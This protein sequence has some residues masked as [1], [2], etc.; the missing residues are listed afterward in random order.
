M[1]HFEALDSHLQIS[2]ALE[3]GLRTWGKPPPVSLDEWA[4][5]NFHLSSES[6]YIE[7]AWN[8]WPFQRGIMHA[9]SRD[10]I[11]EVTIKKSARVGYTKM[12]LAFLLY[13]AHHRRRNQ[14]IWLPSDGDQ[15]K[16]VKTELEPALRDVAAMKEV[17][18]SR[19]MGRHRDNTLTQKKFA[20]CL[21]HILGGGSAKNYRSISVDVGVFDELSA[22]EQDI[23]GEGS[24]FSLGAKRVAGATFPKLVTGSTPKARGWCH[25]DARYQAADERMSYQIACPHCAG[26]HALSWGGPDEPHGF[27]FDRDTRAPDSVRHLCPHCAGLIDQADYLAAADAGV[28]INQAGDLWLH[29]DGR[30]TRHDGSPTSPPRHL[31]FHVWAAYS[32]AVSWPQLVREFFAAH[33]KIET[34]DASMM[35]AFVNTT[36]GDTW[37][38]EIER[39][40]ADELRLRAEPFALRHMPRGCLLLLC[41][42]DVQ[43]NRLE[44]QVWGIGRGGE[45]WSID[46]RVFFGNPGQ[47]DVWH[48]LEQFLLEEKY[49]HACGTEHGIHATAIDS[50]GHHADMVYAFAHTH[51]SRRVHAV[52]GSS[53]TER[54]I[55][56][57]N[58]KVGFSFRGKR[59]R[60][61][62]TLWLVGT[63]LA[64]DRLA[65][66]LEVTT[67]GPG[68][69]HLSNENSDEWFRQLAAEDRVTVRSRHGNQ[70][71]WVPNRKR[72]EVFDMTAYCI[73]LEERLNLWA[74]KNRKW[75][76][77]LEAKAEPPDLFSANPPPQAAKPAPDNPAD[78]HAAEAAAADDET[79][80]S[81]I[82]I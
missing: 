41:G 2:H 47:P 45:M 68:Y 26:H 6:S 34:G 39:T 60:N 44:A 73:W 1:I 53:G 16:F 5:Q 9:L 23:E 72:N 59:E 54:G 36:L 75:W 77:D 10:D 71:R 57:G 74:P 66:R 14:A 43:G 11:A 33:E 55:E 64:K 15:K 8:P 52:K 63:N 67:P 42:V 69:I 40:D 51:R 12:L 25:L 50:G 7:Q 27:K 22:F 38:D 20:G 79:L 81:P 78:N 29:A 65:S 49:T 62:P 58:S 82:P 28:W 56:N 37:Q 4:R 21:L 13:A 18:P 24:P 30:F 61:G 31:A 76:D 46:H 17:M 32:P 48:E 70:T 19:G 35:K 3:R 80:F